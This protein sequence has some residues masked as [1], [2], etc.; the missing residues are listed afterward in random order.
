MS[1]RCVFLVPESSKLADLQAL[2]LRF[3][4]LAGKVPPHL[5]VVFPFVLDWTLDR[6]SALL[7]RQRPS[8]P[9]PLTLGN[10]VL[11]NDFLFFP[12]ENGRDAVA[13]MHDQ[14]YALLPVGARSPI[15]Y[16]PHVTF[17]RRCDGLGTAATLREAEHILPFE[18]VA[19]RL[20]LERIGEEEESEI[21]YEVD[22][23]MP[24]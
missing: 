17:G 9:I 11:M 8:L 15:P 16:V 24:G 13:R 6:L 7:D 23:L 5:T 2:R 4:P 21:E 20:V 1:A 12:L 19:R 14:L 22:G 3:D 18:A 10:P